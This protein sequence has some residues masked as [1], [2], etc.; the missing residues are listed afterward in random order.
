MPGQGPYTVRRMW[1]ANLMQS[2]VKAS[3]TGEQTG[4]LHIKSDGNWFCWNEKICLCS[5][6]TTCTWLIT[7]DPSRS[8][9]AQA[10]LF[11]PQRPPSCQPDIGGK[12]NVYALYP[13]RDLLRCDLSIEPVQRGLHSIGQRLVTALQSSELGDF[14]LHTFS[15]AEGTTT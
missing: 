13:L 6:G 15:A 5:F 7:A 8:L 12:G 9:V 10:P 3:R 14:M 11:W 2:K 1:Q 4:D